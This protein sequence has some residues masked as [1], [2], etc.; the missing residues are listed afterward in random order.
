M[1]SMSDNQSVFDPDAILDV[2]DGHAVRY[3]VIGSMSDR[4]HGVDRFTQDLDVC[5]SIRAPT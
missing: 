4:M 3:V 5:V 1:P 2:L